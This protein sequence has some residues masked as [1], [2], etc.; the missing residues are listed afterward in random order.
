MRSTVLL[1]VAVVVCLVPEVRAASPAALAVAVPLADATAALQVERVEPFAPGARID[2][3]GDGGVRTVAPPAGPWYAG[4]VAGDPGSVAVVT[5]GADGLAGFATSGGRT[6]RLGPDGRGGTRADPMPEPEAA[7]AS[8]GCVPLEEEPVPAPEVPVARAAVSSTTTLLLDLAVDTDYELWARFGSDQATIAAV[9]AN[10]AAVSLIYVRDVHVE[11]RLSYLRLWSTQADPWAQTDKLLALNEARA[12]WQNPANGMATTA[13]PHDIA[14]FLTGK[15][16]IGGGQA[17]LNRLCDPAVSAITKFGSTPQDVQFMAHEIGHQFG[18]PHSHCYLPPLD[19]CWNREA[20]CYSGPVIPSVGTIMSYCHLVGSYN[21]NVFHPATVAL[22]RPKAENAACLKPVCDAY[23]ATPEVCDDQDACTVDTCDAS[24]GCLH[25]PIPGCCHGD[26]D[27]DDGE[28]CTT[29]TCNASARCQHATLADATPCSADD[30]RP[31]SC[32]AGV[33]TA[34][35]APV[36]F[37]GVGC[38]LST[39]AD[40]I[41][42]ASLRSPVRGA[43]DRL[44]A[45]A[46]HQRR[47]AD[48]AHQHGKARAEAKVLTALAQTLRRLDKAVNRIHHRARMDDDLASFLLGTLGAARG[49]LIGLQADLAT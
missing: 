5:L 24:A 19:M 41:R 23:A 35:P 7:D 34:D 4:G 26:R 15:A 29:D 17:Y 8:G 46:A 37:A 12:Y 9:A 25:T 2:V 33:C 18:T 48:R 40:A 42:T 3:V 16:S 38:A 31:R 30:C 49:N 47:A 32:T 20:G 14:H 27:C 28:P 6:W 44:V 43:L 13:G 10:V 36:G 22:I 11:V 1:A 39:M 45:R 21:D